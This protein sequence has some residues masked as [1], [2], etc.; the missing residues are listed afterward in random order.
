MGCYPNN[1]LKTSRI[2][3]MIPIPRKFSVIHPGMIAVAFN[4]M[5]SRISWMIPIVPENAPG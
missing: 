4:F 2:F 3:I 5:M 1:H